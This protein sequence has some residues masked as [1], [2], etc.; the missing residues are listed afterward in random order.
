[1]GIYGGITGDGTGRDRWIFGVFGTLTTLFVGAL[2]TA[3]IAHGN[4]LAKISA[5]LAAVQVQ[6]TLAEN[7]TWANLRD[8]NE[9]ILYIER[10]NTGKTGP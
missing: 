4:L 9:R 10:R 2:V 5:Q 1:M 3:T 6:Q 8:I 7:R